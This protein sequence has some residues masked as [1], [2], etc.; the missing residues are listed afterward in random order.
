MTNP[1]FQ[2]AETGPWAAEILARVHGEAFFEPWDAAAIASALDQPGAFAWV[3]QRDDGEPLGFVLVRAAL[4][5]DGGGEA[6]VLTIATRP[7]ARRR[8]VARALME[9]V[10]GKLRALGAGRLFLEVADDNAPA[11]ALY[12]SLG[13]QEVGRRPAYYARATGAPADAIVMAADIRP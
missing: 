13:F 3:A 1:L 4:F 10:L 5:A 9:A 8:G 11:R 2:L 7:Q 12:E 6:E